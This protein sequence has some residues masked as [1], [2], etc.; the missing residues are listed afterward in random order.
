[1]DRR[2]IRRARRDAIPSAERCPTCDGTG[3]GL[4]GMWCEFVGDD[5]EYRGAELTEPIF[6]DECPEDLGRGKGGLR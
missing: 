3:H 6:F 1:M 2:R 4:G 5:D